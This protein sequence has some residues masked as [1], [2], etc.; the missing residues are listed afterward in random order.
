KNEELI[1]E[2]NNGETYDWFTS[3]QAEINEGMGFKLFESFIQKIY[4]FKAERLILESCRVENNPELK[5][6][7][8]NLAEVLSILQG[9]NPGRFKRFNDSVSSVLP[10]IKAVSVR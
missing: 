9:R 3:Y 2:I 7:M 1:I 8:S 6:D 5:S 4:R 10:Q